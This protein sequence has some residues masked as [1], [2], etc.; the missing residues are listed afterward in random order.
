MLE[1]KVYPI[2]DER[3][4]SRYKALLAQIDPYNPYCRYELLDVESKL[5]GQCLNYFLLT[6]EG[7]PV[8][9]MPFYLERIHIAGEPTAY[10]DVST[11]WGYT[12]P[13]VMP[14][15]STLLRAFWKE[16]DAWHESNNVVTEFIRFN[17]N[18]NHEG[19]SGTTLRTLSNIR[20]RL[21]S[22]EELW[23]GFKRSV[24]KNFNTAIRNQLVCRIY[25]ENIP[26]EKIK[27]FYSIWRGT[28]DRLEAAETYYHPFTYFHSYIKANE[29]CC[30]L[31]IVENP[32]GLPISTELLL[33]NKDTLFSFLGGTDSNY[34]SLR[35]NDLLKIEAMKWAREKGLKYYILGGGLRDGDTLY[36]YKK[37]FFPEE[38]EVIFYTGRK[39][40]NPTVYNELSS[41]AGFE[42]SENG[43][44]DDL[45]SGFFPKYRKQNARC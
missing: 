42:L 30:A 23:S 11:P 20:G 38:P 7:S 43:A 33:F 25:Q 29:D 16:V 3:A 45:N 35:P 1:L 10:F 12:G 32:D 5:E 6:S 22:A 8:V 27:D 41:Y 17:F 37:K 4:V 19:Y 15:N 34:F 18:G 14:Q 28:M 26:F 44:A 24:R 9:L 40:V 36:Q 13:I 31:A 39:V 2:S 21:L